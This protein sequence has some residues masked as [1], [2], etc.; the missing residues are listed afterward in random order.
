MVRRDIQRMKTKMKKRRIKMN[1]YSKK[2]NKIIKKGRSVPD[3]LIAMLEEAA[4][5]DI[6]EDKKTKHHA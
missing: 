3:T 5:Y 2:M 1:D 6:I 4:K